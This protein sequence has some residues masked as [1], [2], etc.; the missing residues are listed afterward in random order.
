MGNLYRS[1][2]KVGEQDSS[3]GGYMSNIILYGSVGK[4][5]LCAGL[6][7]YLGGKVLAL[8]PSNHNSVLE[9]EF[10]D[11][12]TMAISDLNHANVVLDDIIEDFNIINKIKRVLVSGDTK[13][14]KILQNTIREDFDE[15][16][17][18][19]KNNEYPL[20]GVVI[21]EASIM[22]SWI[23]DLVKEEL[24]LTAVGADKKTLGLDWSIYQKEVLKF[25][26]KAL[27]LPVI[28]V[29][30]AGEILPS[31]KKDLTRI[32]P[33]IASGS[34]ARKL[35]DKVS[36][37][38]YVTKENG[39]YKVVLDG[40]KKIQTKEK[41]LPVYSTQKV[42]SEIDITNSP[43]T[44]WKYVYSLREL[45]KQNRKIKLDK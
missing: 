19:A 37:L 18:Y 31:E 3:K 45:E 43:T 41:L 34:S 25:F 22:T 12:L 4:S 40:D 28:T 27:S 21:E 13:K 8:S 14:L 24:N 33:D 20:K 38:F 42:K 7:E 35:I 29:I 17:E 39:R 16:H 11:Y 5:S 36:G 44:F 23:E 2:L 32:V 1:A 9:E 26:T 6:S 10:P 15:L 30:S